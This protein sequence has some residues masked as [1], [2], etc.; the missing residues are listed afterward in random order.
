M[1]VAPADILAIASSLAQGVTEG[2]WR[3]AISRAYYAAFH[4]AT[5]WH[6]ALP[7]PGNPDKARGEHEALI[8]RLVHPG[9][10]CSS[11]QIRTSR[12]LAG[13]LSTLR[14]MRVEADYQLDR[15]VTQERARQA[16]ASSGEVLAKIAEG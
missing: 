15:S 14:A 13:Q 10:S 7:E 5:G 16:C 8:Q 11:T 2:E 12:W 9:K 3:S 6:D 1:S 4:G